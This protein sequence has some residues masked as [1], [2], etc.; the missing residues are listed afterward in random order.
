MVC[1]LVL[2]HFLEPLFLRFGSLACIY[3]ISTM[4]CQLVFCSHVKITLDFYK[5]YD[6]V[7]ATQVVKMTTM[8]R[9]CSIEQKAEKMKNGV[10]CVGK[11][12]ECPSPYVGKNATYYK[13]ILAAPRE[14][15][16]GV[17]ESTFNTLLDV[18]E[19]HTVVLRGRLG[20]FGMKPL[21]MVDGEIVAL[22]S[23]LAELISD[24]KVS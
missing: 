22:E 21:G 10:Y 17:T 8:S 3:K 13:V 2:L 16:V 5:M 12:V 24:A 7:I 1:H 15:E 9:S 19:G 11:L 14:T 6:I 4:L 20:K 18:A 23:E